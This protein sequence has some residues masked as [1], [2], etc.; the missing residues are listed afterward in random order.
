MTR[1]LYQ[2][3]KRPPCIVQGGLELRIGENPGV[4]QRK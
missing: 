1:K 2:K 4:P 3:T